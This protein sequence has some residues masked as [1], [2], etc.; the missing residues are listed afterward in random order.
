MVFQFCNSNALHYISE[1][2]TLS[3]STFEECDEEDDCVFLLFVFL[4]S[5]RSIARS[6]KGSADFAS[7]VKKPHNSCTGYLHRSTLTRKCVVSSFR[8]LDEAIENSKLH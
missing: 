8:K 5:S 1:A 7:Q 6:R 4:R 2:R 3:T